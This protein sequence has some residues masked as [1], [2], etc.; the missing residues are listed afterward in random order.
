MQKLLQLIGVVEAEEVED[1]C[2]SKANK[3]SNEKVYYIIDA[4]ITAINNNKKVSFL[5]FDYGVNG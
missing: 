3:H 1:V 5:Y 2:V 4:L